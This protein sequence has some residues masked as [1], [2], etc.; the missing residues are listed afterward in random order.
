PADKQTR[1]KN[2]NIIPYRLNSY[3]KTEVD[4]FAG[5]A[6]LS[7]NADGEAHQQLF[8]DVLIDDGLHEYL[9]NR[10][11][12]AFW[13]R[14][15]HPSHGVYFMEDMPIAVLS[16]QTAQC[17]AAGTSKNIWNSFYVEEGG[18]HVQHVTSRRESSWWRKKETSDI[19]DAE[20]EPAPAGDL[21][22]EMEPKVCLWLD[23]FLNE[24]D[25]RKSLEL[26][27]G[28]DV[29]G[30]RRAA[31]VDHIYHEP[32]DSRAKN[33]YEF[34]AE[35][36]R[37]TS[38]REVRPAPASSSQ[39]TS[40]D[41]VVL[42][43]EQAHPE[44]IASIV[45]QSAFAPVAGGAAR[46]MVE[47]QVQTRIAARQVIFETNPRF[48]CSLPNKLV[49]CFAVSDPFN[50]RSIVVLTKMTTT[51]FTAHQPQENAFAATDG[52]SGWTDD[53]YPRLVPQRLSQS[54]QFPLPTRTDQYTDGTCWTHFVKNFIGYI[55]EKATVN[56]GTHDAYLTSPAAG[57]PGD[58]KDSERG[59]WLLSLVPDKQKPTQEKMQKVQWIETY[60]RFTC[61]TAK[62]DRRRSDGE[63]SNSVRALFLAG[64]SAD[65][66]NA[67]DQAA[68]RQFSDVKVAHQQERAAGAYIGM[69]LGGDHREGASRSPKNQKNEA[70]HEASTAALLR[71]QASKT[72][73]VSYPDLLTVEERKHHL[74]IAADL[75]ENAYAADKLRFLG[76]DN[77]EIDITEVAAASSA[78]PDDRAIL[79]R[80]GAR[81]NAEFESEVGDEDSGKTTNEPPQEAKQVATR[82]LPM[83]AALAEYIEH[84]FNIL[85]H[86]R[87]IN[88]EDELALILDGVWIQ[89]AAREYE[90]LLVNDVGRWKRECV[91]AE[92]EFEDKTNSAA[93]ASSVED[94]DSR[95]PVVTSFVEQEHADLLRHDFSF[96]GQT[97]TVVGMKMINADDVEAEDVWALMSKALV[98]IPNSDLRIAAAS[99]EDAGHVGVGNQ[100]GSFMCTKYHRWM[101]HTRP[102]LAFFRD[103][104]A[105]F[106]YRMFWRRR[107]NYTTVIEPP[108][109]ENA[110]AMGEEK[111]HDSGARHRQ[112]VGSKIETLLQF[113][114]QLYLEYAPIFDFLW[115]LLVR[116]PPYD[117]H[118]CCGSG[119]EQRN[120]EDRE[121]GS[122]IRQ[123][124]AASATPTTD[125]VNRSASP[126]EATPSERMLDND[127]AQGG[128]SWGTPA[129]GSCPVADPDKQNAFLR[130]CCLAATVRWTRNQKTL[131]Y[132][133]KSRTS[134]STKEMKNKQIKSHSTCTKHKKQ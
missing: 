77:P 125:T 81:G 68:E 110:N 3:N 93:A 20:Q 13:W 98:A 120:S 97:N 56:R 113:W 74:A 59:R 18:D 91:L 105:A 119:T 88:A 44:A 63:E 36:V 71:I 64:P 58:P 121:G 80:C 67:V 99:R 30:G 133:S 22:D 28:H 100:Q 45:R 128:S 134:R 5:R 107:D 26:G 24:A 21:E 38:L 53:Y 103:L 78:D 40:V 27:N 72:S 130:T 43:P 122:R 117:F 50:A 2:I 76:Y 39:E 112:E 6:L 92:L 69:H 89:K 114:R 129:A 1:N 7:R 10:A 83:A 60:Y 82:I 101:S 31:S 66:R 126:A 94:V 132:L 4:H 17:P 118:S 47:N 123:V 115:A 108:F 9:A 65:R 90:A 16:P 14:F 96:E 57:G 106:Y 124:E 37:R 25:V 62:V 51:A 32:F 29:V 87:Q 95:N 8:F 102:R 33:A 48:T 11:T 131:E 75:L 12:L 23:A 19:D 35:A 86:I 116:A 85:H 127:L 15:V 52:I 34:V 55:T 42:T 54:L 73:S 104:G 84:M 70:E 79:S 61:V 49:N 109:L 111:G 41:S 46:H